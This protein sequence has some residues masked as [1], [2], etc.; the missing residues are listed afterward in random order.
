MTPPNFL[1]LITDQ[2]R[3]PRHW[4]QDPAWLR[5]LMPNDTELARTG[6]TF[7]KAFCNTAMCSPSRA[8]LFTGL[9]PAEHGM[10]LTLTAADL[11]PNPRYA[12]AVAATMARILRRRE[13]PARRLLTQFGKGLLRIG[14]SRGQEP[15]LPAGLPNMA[16]L[17][18]SAG[19]HV[20]YKGKWHLTHPS[21][22][23]GGLLGGWGGADERRIERDYGFADWEAPDAGEN[24]KA[25]HFGGGNA[26]EGEGWDEVYTGQ[27]ERWLSGPALPEPFCLVVSL[28]NPHD[29]LGYPGSYE[30][31]GYS[32]AEFRDL[33]VRLPPT[34][35]ED[36]TGKPAV[37]AL[38]QMGMT[39]YMGPLRN[40]RD[41]LDYVN[42]YAYLH[43]LVDA[44][45][46][47]ILGALGDGSDPGSLRSRTVVIRCADHGEMGL[48]HGGLRQK[49]FNAYEETINVPLVV[50]N[51]VLYPKGADTGALASLVDV[52]PTMLRVGGVQAPD[53]LRGRDLTPVLAD[54][55]AP[56]REPLQRVPVALTPVTN[57]PAPAASVR[58]HV[59][60]TYD[61]HQAGTAM[62]EAPGQPN[63]IRAIRTAGAK[64]AFYFDPHGRKPTE[65]ELYDLERDPLEA[66]NR[67]DVRSGQ[68]RDPATAALRHELAQRLDDAMEEGGTTPRIERSS[69]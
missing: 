7:R 48:S 32:A 47:R 1:V 58:D 52:L 45:I 61:D 16:K 51:P 65:F 23:E 24:A 10:E 46:G 3:A 38:M 68:P 21:T 8:S 17:L 59:H 12:P 25:E 37:H 49:T 42:F 19:Y 13:V 62:T 54:A 36:L 26:G 11:R 9:Y 28:I 39:A 34:V 63:R 35:D 50:S 2:Q 4:P 31:G 56:D 30:R 41:Q 66:E 29:V 33:G 40:R 27:V 15:E 60:F 18:R 64:Y 69:R 20:A 5:E 67:L 55:A 22:G 57:H 14:E 43:G 53:G 6:L 44:K